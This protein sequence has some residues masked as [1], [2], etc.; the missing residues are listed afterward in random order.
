M[1]CEIPDFYST[2]T[3]KARKPHVCCECSGSIFKGERH[4]QVTGKWE[5]QIS[6]FRQHLICERA[7]EFIRD[8]IAD[9]CIGYGTLFEFCNDEGYFKYTKHDPKI[10]SFRHLIARILWRKREQSY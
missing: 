10:K 6:S 9:E 1:E 4:F 7:C 5:G 8:K 2:S 3:P